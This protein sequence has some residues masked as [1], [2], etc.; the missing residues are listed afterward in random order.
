MKSCAS[1]AKEELV[2]DRKWIGD[3]HTQ[4]RR[5]AQQKFVGGVSR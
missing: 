4:R 1:I 3:V 5:I 2:Y